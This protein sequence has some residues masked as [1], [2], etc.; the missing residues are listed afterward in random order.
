MATQNNG[1]NFNDSNYVSPDIVQKY[2]NLFY[3]VNPK[4]AS[5]YTQDAL[6]WFRDRISKDLKPDQASLL[7]T[8]LYGKKTGTENAQLIGKMYFYEYKAETAG[9]KELGV[10]DRYP[11]VFFFASGKTKDGKLILTGLNMHY[12][13]GKER[14]LLLWELLKAKS[15]N[16]LRPQSRLKLTWEIIKGVS[17]SKLYERAVHSYRLDRL[18]TKLVEIPANDW[19]VVTFLRTEKWIALDSNSEMYPSEYRQ[20]LQKAAKSHAK[21]QAAE[22]NTLFKPTNLK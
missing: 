6:T 22:G 13:T 11:L 8:T 14:Q 21:A 7:D 17:D 4:D 18:Q 15:S 12:L 1:L 19:S 5:R 20:H 2:K 9:W 3:K 10:Y 16:V